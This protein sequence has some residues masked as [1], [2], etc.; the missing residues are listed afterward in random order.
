MQETSYLKENKKVLDLLKRIK[1]FQT[2][3][4]NDLGSFLEVGKLKSY[5][6]GE[7]IIKKGDTDHWVYFLVSG[8]V[9][10]VKGEKTFAILKHG[11]DLFGE[12]GV[13]DQEPR[14]ASVWALTQTMVLGLD[15]SHLD[16]AE[17]AQ[18]SV[19]H[20]T[21]FRLFA[22]SLAE[23][24]RVTN[25]EIMK[26]QAELKEKNKLLAKLTDDAPDSETLWV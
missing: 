24:L 1:K 5:E 16:Q 25:N 18:G 9:K 15:C 23:R 6:A 19:F 13:I 11:G 26:L 8:Q 2:F 22:E 7:T 20:Y 3:S 12:M 21:I 4:D 17:K 10:I 14:S